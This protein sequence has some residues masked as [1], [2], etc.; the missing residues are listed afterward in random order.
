VYVEGAER[1]GEG[2]AGQSPRLRGQGL[3]RWKCTQVEVWG[4]EGFKG[5]TSWTLRRL[6][7]VYI[8]ESAMSKGRK[9]G[10]KGLVGPRGSH[11]GGIGQAE[12]YLGTCEILKGIKRSNGLRVLRDRLC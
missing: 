3:Q 4:R 10:E 7:G 9:K 5:E 8:K 12:G 2:K 11:F 6:E 1:G